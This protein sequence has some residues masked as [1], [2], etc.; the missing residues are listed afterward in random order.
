MV[1]IIIIIIIIIIVV[2]VII[3][4]FRLSNHNSHD[5]NG[6]ICSSV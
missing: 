3:I 1:I 6:N 5:F 2:I 4:T